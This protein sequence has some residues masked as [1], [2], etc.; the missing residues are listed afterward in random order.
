MM[1]NSQPAH[2]IFVIIYDEYGF[3]SDGWQTYGDLAE[4]N[5]HD[6]D[7]IGIYAVLDDGQ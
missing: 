1:R 7:D 6:D 2:K 3:R 5:P 4:L